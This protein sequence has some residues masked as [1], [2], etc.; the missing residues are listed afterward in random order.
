MRHRTS[1]RW[2]ALGSTIAAILLAAP[3]AGADYGF[4]SYVDS[5]QV[6]HAPTAEGVGDTSLCIIDQNGSDRWDEGE[7][8]VIRFNNTCDRVEYEDRCLIC[9]DDKDPGSE[10]EMD[11][12]EYDRFLTDVDDHNLTYVDMAAEGELDPD[13]PTY[14]DIRNTQAERVDPGDVRLTSWQDH[15]ALTTV[16]AGDSDVG[17]SMSHITGDPLAVGDEDALM[18]GPD[19]L[20]LNT[21]GGTPGADLEHIP[22][23]AIRLDTEVQ[24]PIDAKIEEALA[25]RQ[26]PAGN[27]TIRVTELT[28]RPDEPTAGGLVHVHLTVENQGDGAGT[29]TVETE[30][31]DTLADARATPQLDPGQT[32]RLAVTLPIADDTDEVEISAGPI[33][34]PLDVEPASETEPNEDERDGDEVQ[35]QGTDETSDRR[36]PRDQASVPLL[37]AAGLVALLGLVAARQ[38]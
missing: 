7:P 10:I 32:A 34:R 26:E 17:A 37:P 24:E 2:I 20:Y 18:E 11:D 1:A 16:E 28:V 5:G 30:M 8:L 38:R 22:S 3:L 14:I 27:A 6:D 25:A 21:D 9:L 31:D 23:D 33:E 36:Q 35:A 13:N 19:G 15:E 4:G 12:P 29:S